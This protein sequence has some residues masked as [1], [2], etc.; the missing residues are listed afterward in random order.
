MKCV[1]IDNYPPPSPAVTSFFCHSHWYAGR[2]GGVE[3]RRRVAGADQAGVQTGWQLFL[4]R[5]SHQRSMEA[6]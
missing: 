2:G 4:R 5:K 3:P 1:Q 6:H